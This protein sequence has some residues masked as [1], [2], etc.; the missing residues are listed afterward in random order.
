M[1]KSN[2]IVI[3]NTFRALRHRNYRLFFMGQSVS[4]IGT[5]MQNMAQQL[6]VYRLTGSAAALG[7]VN[8]LALIPLIPFSLWGGSL[9]DRMPKRN[10]VIGTQFAMMVQAVILAI[11]TW[12]GWIEI[13]HVF[14]LSFV[15]GAINAVDVPARLAFTIDMVEGKEDLTNAIGL[16]STMFNSARIFGPAMAGIIVAATGEGTAFLLNG[17]T[18]LAVIISLLSMRGLPTKSQPVNVKG[19]VMEHMAEGWRYIRKRQIVL[20]LFSLVGVSA[21]LSMPYSTLMPVFADEVLGSSAKPVIEF[22][23]GSTAINWQCVAPEALPLGLLLAMVGL[24]AVIGS[25]FV[26]SLPESASRGKWLTIGNIFFPFFLLIFSQSKSYVFSMILL[27]LAGMCF[28]LQNSL[29]NTLIQLSVPDE[30]RGRVMSLYSMTNQGMMRLGGLQAGLLA[31]RWSAPF[32]VGIG[33]F[34]SLLYS[35]F[36]FVRF[37]NIKKL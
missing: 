32:S 14:L 11:L 26:A 29:A 35:L 5:W 4:L 34:I 31:D 2:K 36:V 15:L 27:F 21:F 6:L 37:K 25:L 22:F 17:C 18:F 24:G 1:H 30:L 9:T 10:I 23:C 19:H 20:I 16:N 8:L 13:W 33:T 3:P 28:I 7:M 12:S